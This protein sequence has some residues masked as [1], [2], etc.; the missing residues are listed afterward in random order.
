MCQQVSRAKAQASNTVA[1]QPPLP[2]EGI[3]IFLWPRD[4]LDVAK[5]IDAQIRDR[6]PSAAAIK[7]EAEGDLLRTSTKQSIPVVSTP[8][9][10]YAEKYNRNR[11]LYF[12]EHSYENTAYAAPSR[13]DTTKGV[14]H[15]ISD[16][17]T[18]DDITRSLVYKKYPTVLQARRMAKT[19]SV[20]IVFE[21]HLVS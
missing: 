4:G 15:N 10:A 9:M 14:I 13:E 20:I 16:Y 8:N 1:P 21:G 2:K 6:V 11:Q 18:T 3:N 19:N 17:D 12:G 7:E 5:F